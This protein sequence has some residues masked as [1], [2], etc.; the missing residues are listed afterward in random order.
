M[1]TRTFRLSLTIVASLLLVGCVS[2]RKYADLESANAA[3]RNDYEDLQARYE[4]AT[5]QVAE[6]L[7]TIAD[8]RKENLQLTDDLKRAQESY[9]RLDKTNRDLLD[10]YDRLIETNQNALAS[11][12]MELQKANEE[13]ARKQLEADKRERELRRLEDTLNKREADLNKQIA[14]LQGNVGQLEGNLAAREQRVKEL[15]AALGEKDRKLAELRQKV[16]NALLGFTDAQLTVR[17]QGGK[18]YVSLSEQLLFPSGSATI[19][20][21]GRDAI[22]KVAG[23]LKDSRDIAITVE[24]HTDEVGGSDYNWDL[25]VRRATSVVKVLVDGGLAPTRVV[26]SGRGE[27]LPVADNSTPEGRARNRRT[28]IILTPNLDALFNLINQ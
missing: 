6:Q 21:G 24:G 16:K 27:Y 17:E 20:A 8:L 28:E 5:A 10:R 12:S 26:A 7:Q 25:S 2:S 3:L 18:I 4:Q 1:Y 22:R 9:N 19:N 14:D 15:E 11:S 23:V 13:L